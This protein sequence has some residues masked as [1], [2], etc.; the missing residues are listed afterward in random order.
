MAHLTEGGE[1][2]GP[3]QSHLSRLGIEPPGQSGIHLPQGLRQQ[4]GR[5]LAGHQNH[6]R[7]GELVPLD[8]ETGAGRFGEGWTGGEGLPMAGEW[9]LVFQSLSGQ[10]ALNMLLQLEKNG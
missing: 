9:E 8:C 10:I 2:F 1:S 7:W 5:L 6:R 3:L 4:G